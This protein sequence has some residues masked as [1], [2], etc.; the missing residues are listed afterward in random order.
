MNRKTVVVLFAAA[1]GAYAQG[2]GRGRGFGP[3]PGGPQARFLGAEAG[4]PGR[5]VKN[6]PFTADIVTE[7]TQTLP[8]GN[9]IRQS[10]TVKLYR[11]SDGRTR[12]EQSP[13]LNGLTGS[14]S[15]PSLVFIHDPVAG[16]SMALNSKDETGTRSTF[17]PR[18]A[19]GGPGGRGPAPHTA[20]EQSA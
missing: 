4:M 20:G 7:S 18:Q 16:V 5:V 8:D 19:G 10:N 1:L 13:N 6:A 17:T 2:P 3:P 15:M 12:R 9:H 11:D 14:T